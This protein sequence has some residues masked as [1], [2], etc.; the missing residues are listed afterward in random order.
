MKKSAAAVTAAVLL[1]SAAANAAYNQSD[2]QNSINSSFEW[3][4]HNFSALS[5][6]GTAASDFYIMALS[7]M[8]KEYSY[9]KYV[10]LTEKINPTTK[11]DGQR[12]IM[13]N[14]ACGEHLNDSFVAI[15]TY[16]SDFNSAADLAGAVI[17]LGSG[18]FTAKEGSPSSENLAATLLTYQQANGSFENDMLSTAKAVIALSNYLDYEF[19]IQGENKNEVYTYNTNDAVYNAVEYLSGVQG[20]DGGFSTVSNTV[21]TIIAL[22]S[23]GIDA[24]NDERFIK[25]G[26]SP[27]AFLMSM[28]LDDGSFNSSAEDTALSACALVSHLRAMQGKTKFFN[29]TSDDS[30]DTIVS[31]QGSSSIAAGGSS[32]SNSAVSGGNTSGSSAGSSTAAPSA[33]Q[34]VIRV[35]PMPTR[36]PEHSSLNEEQ[37]G[38]FPF[39]GPQQ[40]EDKQDTNKTAAG[41]VSDSHSSGIIIIVIIGII[42]LLLLAAAVYICRFKPELLSKID[43]AKKLIPDKKEQEPPKE[44]EKDLLAEIDSPGEAVP[45][46]ELYDPDFIKKLIPVDELDSSIGSLIENDEQSNTDDTNDTDETKT[47]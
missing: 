34:S 14:A 33:T 27:L 19:E 30:V 31:G 24:D 4:E 38:P 13:S 10:D 41:T 23:I 9:S 21:Y 3:M 17:T 28:Q 1:F 25:N 39:V 40:Q 20:S 7:R 22:D 11:Q 45:T 18:G 26:S 42:I 29:F 15:F 43:I 44:P 35:T 16:D 8:N 46:E 12:L 6:P 37:Y 32:H 5:N 2:I 47:E 36:E